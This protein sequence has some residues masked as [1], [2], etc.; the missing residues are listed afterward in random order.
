ME[1]VDR[2]RVA[3]AESD[4]AKYEET[5]REGSHKNKQALDARLVAIDEEAKKVDTEN[6]DVHLRVRGLE[7]WLT[8]AIS[9]I[10]AI[11]LK[12]NDENRIVQ[13]ELTRSLEV[14]REAA[15]K[16]KV[17]ITADNEV[18]DAEIAV[19]SEALL[20]AQSEQAVAKSNYDTYMSKM[21]RA[22]DQGQLTK[23][24]TEIES[25]LAVITNEAVKLKNDREWLEKSDICPR[26]NNQ[27]TADHRQVEFA[28]MQGEW[29]GLT[30]RR[31]SLLEEQSK[32]TEQLRVID[33]ERVR[34]AE[35]SAE[36]TNADK[37][38]FTKMSE[39][40][41]IKARPK[42]DPEREYQT[43]VEINEP[44]ITNTFKSK[45]KVYDAEAERNKARESAARTKL[46]LLA[47]IKP[48]A[49]D[50][51]VAMA[52]AEFERAENQLLV[53]KHAVDTALA[54]ARSKLSLSE[55]ATKAK[56]EELARIQI[57]MNEFS[58]QTSRLVKDETPISLAVGEYNQMVVLHQEAVGTLESARHRLAVIDE[59]RKVL[60]DD[61]AKQ[62]FIRKFVAALN[63]RVNHH[64]HYYGLATSV[65][66]DEALDLVLWN[67][68]TPKPVVY[69]QHSGGEQ[70]RLAISI[71]MSMVELSMEMMSWRSGFMFL[72]EFLDEGMDEKGMEDTFEI[73]KSYAERKGIRLYVISHKISGDYFVEKMKIEKVGGF[74]TVRRV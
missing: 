54:D 21:S 1:A 50:E 13:D 39:L 72:D 69:A 28:R 16:V 18:I 6:Q 47:L 46:E 20:K 29:N 36:C 25:E 64:L 9:G 41:V 40:N 5:R 66:F 7:D 65:Q 26:C 74:T 61:G 71:L 52:N 67:S 15:S 44:K 27:I 11:D 32:I 56:Q 55:A 24:N 73:L 22:N 42:L 59:V 3:S 10:D 12:T 57:E 17:K 49:R 14:M 58:E 8:N 68:A 53:Y 19:A 35:L 30:T 43:F 51:R 45:I 4:S 38:V 23:R 70:R 2:Q 63:G 60:S 33:E 34:I 62:T 37:L 48:F 31:Q